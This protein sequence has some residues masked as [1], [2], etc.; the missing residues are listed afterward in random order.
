[1]EISYQLHG[2]AAF[3]PIKESPATLDMRLG[4]NPKQVRKLRTRES[5]LPVSVNKS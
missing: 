5:L 1:M 2:P 4:G 3:L